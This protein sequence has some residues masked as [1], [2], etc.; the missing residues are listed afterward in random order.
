[1]RQKYRICQLKK[2]KTLNIQEYAVL[3]KDTKNVSSDMLRDDHFDLVA[4]QKY[5]TAAIARSVAAGSTALVEALRT[6]NLFPIAP[7]A[8]KIAESVIALTQDDNDRCIELFFDD[9]DFFVVDIP[10]NR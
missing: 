5:E 10:V 7:Y 3:E 9:N 8:V 4:E 6:P 1:M 2:E